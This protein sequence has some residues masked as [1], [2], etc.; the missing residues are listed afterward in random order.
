[1]L[2]ITVLGLIIGVVM[3]GPGL[4][5]VRAYQ[6]PKGVYAASAL[7]LFLIVGSLTTFMYVITP[8]MGSNSGLGLGLIY[9]FGSVI[10]IVTALL[11]CAAA[12]LRHI[13]DF[14]GNAASN[15]RP[16]SRQSLGN[17]SPISR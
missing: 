13:I 2:D 11:A 5:A 3:A 9:Y 17:S 8:F 15:P 4:L 6:N 1:M 14:V 7:W 12:T 16:G 10:T